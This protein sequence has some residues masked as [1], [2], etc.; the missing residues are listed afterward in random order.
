MAC[1]DCEF[2][3]KVANSVLIKVNQP[4]IKKSWCYMDTINYFR[5]MLQKQ[6]PDKGIIEFIG[7]MNG[8]LYYVL[9]Y[10]EYV[11]VIGEPQIIECDPNDRETVRVL[12]DMELYCKL[13]KE[14]PD[15]FQ[16][17]DPEVL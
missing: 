6:A 9:E 3:D 11:G 10:T 8:R 15:K 12:C 7:K 17:D 13:A 16:D 5:T 1:D 4:S 14:F 2:D